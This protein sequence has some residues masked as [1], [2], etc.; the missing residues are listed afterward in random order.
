MSTPTPRSARP[1]LADVAEAAGV[2]KTAVS[3]SL[4]RTGRVAEDTRRVVLEVAERLGYPIPESRPHSAGTIAAILSP[5]RHHGETPNYYVSEVLAGVESAATARGYQV[6]I[7]FWEGAPPSLVRDPD[8]NGLLFIGGAFDPDALARLRR[9]GVLVGT[10]FSSL[11]HDAVLADNRRGAYLATSHLLRIG[12]TRLALINGP[13]DAPT[14]GEKLLGFNDALVEHGIDPNDVPVRYAGFSTESGDDTADALLRSATPPDALV[15]ADDT[16]AVGAL[17][18]AH[19]RGL[20]LAQ[21][22]A[23]VG[24]GD[25]PMAAS[26]NPGL[27]SVRVF[28]R[29]MGTVAVQQLHAV[30]SNRT[31]RSM[32]ILID[33]ELVT[34]GSSQP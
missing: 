22:L 23:I 29:R 11:A 1:T 33:P 31:D 21:Q 16:I 14:S 27:S 5:T 10:S 18:A 30:L 17:H 32:R 26:T 3:Y 12:R 13:V 34:R 24:Y 6:R 8:V 15:T 7:S 4:N 25:G 2:S 28:Q 20:T 19:R 9:P